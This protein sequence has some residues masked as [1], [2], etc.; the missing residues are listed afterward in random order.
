M[1][2]QGKSVAP[3]VHPRANMRNCYKKKRESYADRLMLSQEK[4]SYHKLA[5]GLQKLGEFFLH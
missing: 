1:Q 3:T 2:Y 4:K 5:L